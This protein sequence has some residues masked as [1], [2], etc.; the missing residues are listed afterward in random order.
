MFNKDELDAWKKQPISKKLLETLESEKDYLAQYIL[1]GG[2]MQSTVMDREYGRAVGRMDT[3]SQILSDVM[4]TSPSTVTED[5]T[6]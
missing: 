4:F 2:L 1:T 6:E 5:E 3:I